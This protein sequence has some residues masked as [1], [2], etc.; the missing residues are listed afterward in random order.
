LA[1]ASGI[2]FFPF[3]AELTPSRKGG[4]AHHVANAGP[5]SP[6][7]H[8]ACFWLPFF[9]V[10]TSLDCPVRSFSG[11]ESQVQTIQEGWA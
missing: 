7:V 4:F 1:R 6:A 2:P 10:R 3:W 9:E 11:R 5:A 8:L